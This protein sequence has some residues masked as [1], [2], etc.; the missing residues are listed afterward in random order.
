MKGRVA[1]ITRH[2]GDFEIREYPVPEVEPDAAVVKITRGGVCGSDLHIWRGELADLVGEP[3]RG[4]TF[5]HEM[6]G[7]VERLGKNVITD[8]TGQPLAEGDRVTYCY[9]YPC[10]RCPA[11]LDGLR[12]HCPYKRRGT[13]YADDPPHFIG[14][15]ADYYYLRPGHFVYKVPD[16]ISDDVATPVNC[17][18]AQVLYGLDRVRVRTGDTVV[19]QGAGG[20]GINATAVAKEMGAGQVI[21]IDQIPERLEL[22][23]RFGADHTLNIQELSRPED[24]VQ[25]VRD[26]TRGWGADVV[27]DFVGFPRVIP[28]GLQMLKSGG[29]YLE[30]GTISPSLS[31]EL[32]PAQLV[33]G[34][35]TIVGMIQYEPWAI[36]KA[37]AFLEKNLTKYPFTEVI[38]HTYPLERITDAFRDA[39]WLGKQHNPHKISRAAIAPWPN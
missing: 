8:S 14:S 15:F 25:A 34:S 23:R 7:V 20:L 33:W 24:R 3:S 38:S 16:R 9:F 27:C 26:L 35:K 1:V 12:A 10:G 36:Q 32:S 19:M 31:V 21:I 4:L 17:A 13:R 6:C 28:E 37:L 11:C 18:L 29:T 39:E 30:I 5:G 22:A 2:S